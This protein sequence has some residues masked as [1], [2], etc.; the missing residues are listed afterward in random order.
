MWR[1]LRPDA[2]AVLRDESAKKSLA[3]YFAVM[4]D[5][6]PAKF[7]IAKKLPAEFSEKDSNEMLWQKHASLT[8]EFCEMEREIDRGHESLAKMPTPSKSYLDLKIEIANRILLSCHFCTRKCHVN[9]LRGQ[10]GYCRCGSKITVSSIFE[11]TGEEPEL[12][13]SGTV[14]TMG[15][16]MRCKHCQNWTISQWEERG[17]L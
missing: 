17:S 15:C 16:T 13:P 2:H 14:F 4:Q 1:L 10:L 12:V 3:R 9:R 8:Q 11:H 7:A 6:K 5:E